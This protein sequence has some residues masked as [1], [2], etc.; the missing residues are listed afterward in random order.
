MSESATHTRGGDSP[1]NLITGEP[2][3][4]KE[5]LERRVAEGNP[6]VE[7]E[8]RREPEPRQDDDAER[9]AREIADLRNRTVNA[10][11]Q[12]AEQFRLRQVAERDRVAA[13]QGAEDTGFTAIN[14]A[15]SSAEQEKKSLLAEMKTAGEAGEFGRVGE[16]SARLGEL[17]AEIRDL[18]QGKQQ[19]EQDRQARLSRPTDRSADRVPDSVFGSPIAHLGVSRD[20]YMASKTPMT[21][22]W[23]NKHPEFFSDS[24]AAQRIMG[25]HG[26]AVGRGLVADTPE[27]FRFVE[28]NALS[29]TQPPRQR[30]TDRGSPGA[31]PSR[32]APGPSGRPR[33]AN[34]DVYVSQEDKT[35]AL[36]MNVDPVEYVT[37]RQRLKEEGAWPYRRR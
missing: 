28:E 24:G 2:P 27:Y 10:E 11:A 18:S 3:G 14:T 35:A 23:L 22:D 15:L 7:T 20:A 16:I 30:E 32:D 37:E 36:W 34:G 1:L 31:A 33:A 5:I 21:Q 25:A 6:P 19:F 9:A 17:G 4:I 26:L 12:A 8:E 29:Q 13:V